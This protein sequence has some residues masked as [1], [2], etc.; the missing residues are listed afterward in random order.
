VVGLQG[1]HK[2]REHGS[3]CVK[4]FIVHWVR[5]NESCFHLVHLDHST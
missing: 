3:V 2:C 1:L 4:I 5:I